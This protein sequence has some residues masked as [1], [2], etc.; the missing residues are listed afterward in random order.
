MMIAEILLFMIASMLMVITFCAV[1]ITRRILP[2]NDS[3]AVILSAELMGDI[4]QQNKEI[5][6]DRAERRRKRRVPFSHSVN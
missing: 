6:K 1:T 4:Q 2:H 5:A 3:S